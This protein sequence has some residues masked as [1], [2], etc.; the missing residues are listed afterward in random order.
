MSTYVVKYY[1]NT[2]NVFL[3]T[4]ANTHTKKNFSLHIAVLFCMKGNEIKIMTLFQRY[5]IIIILC[6]II[7]NLYTWWCC[8]L[9]SWRKHYHIQSVIVQYF[10]HIED[11]I[12]N[13]P[14]LCP[15]KTMYEHWEWEAIY[16]D[17]MCP[18]TA[19]WVTMW[20]YTCYMSLQIHTQ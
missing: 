20:L 17:H 6:K 19:P 13:I 15:Q 8:V 12:S 3:W 4:M 10:V 2:S 7:S 1:F 14:I 5:I 9:L 18:H 11:P 16:W